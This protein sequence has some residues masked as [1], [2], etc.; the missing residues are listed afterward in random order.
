MP[1]NE[2]QIA[3]DSL[4]VRY[5]LGE[6]PETEAEPLDLSSVADDDFAAR[7]S[8]VEN[9]LV[10][11]YVRG[12]LEG[13]TLERF[14]SWFLASEPRRAKVALA[15]A[16]LERERTAR[17]ADAA[18]SRLSWKASSTRRRTWSLLAAAMLILVTSG[19]LLVVELRPKGPESRIAE[20]REAA[21]PAV[22]AEEPVTQLPSPPLPLP[23]EEPGRVADSRAEAAPLRTISFLVAPQT[24][25]GESVVT[26]SVPP[27]TDEVTAR[28]QLE[29]DEFP[30]YEVVLKN[31]ATDESLWRSGG[32]RP[33]RQGAL[34]IVSARLPASLLK[35]Q[36]YSVELAGLSSDGAPE[37]IGNYVFRAVLE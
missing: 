30:Q 4:L 7:L 29:F 8:A 31:P 2:N 14:T 25:A 11:A 5:L 26:V 20:R 23:A 18:A 37:F 32:L 6:L 17:V 34:R 9:D 12:D 16:L 35:T 15:A 21:A 3:D 22:T 27:G 24:R 28:L 13:E 19:Y 1:S 10:D 33:R 36:N